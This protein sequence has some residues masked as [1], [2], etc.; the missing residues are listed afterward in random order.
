MGGRMINSIGN[1]DPARKARLLEVLDIN[2]EWRMHLVSDGQ[3]R[4]VQLAIGLL[5]PFKVLLLDEVTVDL[6]A[7]ARRSLL[8][9]LKNEARERGATIVYTTHIFDGMETWPDHLLF[10]SQ[11]AVKRFS[12]IH[13]FPALMNGKTTMLRLVESWLRSE[14]VLEKKLKQK[15]LLEQQNNTSDNDNDSNNKKFAYAFNN[16]FSSGTLNT[17][18]AGSS[19]SVL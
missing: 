7:L 11:G 15:R 18:L 8:N 6:D 5:K 9:F 17:S 2:E 13:E 3:R 14:K 4:R 10:C 1:I 19:N 12:P 16:G